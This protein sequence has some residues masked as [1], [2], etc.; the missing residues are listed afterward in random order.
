MNLERKKE[1]D[2]SK[3]VHCGMCIKDCMQQCL[4][5]DENRIPR[6]TDIR[7]CGLCEHCMAVCPTGA[8]SFGGVDPEMLRDVCYANSDELLDL[9]KSRRSTRQYTSADIPGEKLENLA[10]M[11]A[12]PPR[13]GNC[14]SLRFSLVGSREKMHEIRDVT[15]KSLSRARAPFTNMLV[16]GYA[17]GR[18]MVFWDA[19]AMLVAFVS[20]TNVVQGC[21]TVDPIISLSYAELYAN[22]LGL[23]TV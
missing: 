9:I 22:S 16:N 17:N 3:C 11:L 2:Q 21:A 8:L 13:G 15:Y 10:E 5:F 18:D 12:Y 20:R 23:G 19:P 4:K 14:D 6:F 1:V 7:M